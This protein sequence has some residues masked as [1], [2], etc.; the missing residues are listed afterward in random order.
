MMESVLGLYWLKMRYDI[1]QIIIKETAWI[2][3]RSKVK[4]NLNTNGSLQMELYALLNPTSVCSIL[5]D[6]DRYFVQ[7]VVVG[8]S[9]KNKFLI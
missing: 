2:D 7:G 9:P 4:I 1:V 5:C 3:N 6:I 8:I